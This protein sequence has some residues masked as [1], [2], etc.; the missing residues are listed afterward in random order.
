[1]IAQNGSKITGVTTDWLA[2]VTAIAEAQRWSGKDLFPHSGMPSFAI[3]N[4]KP[5]TTKYA[6]GLTPAAAESMAQRSMT[7]PA[8]RAAPRAVRA[9]AGRRVRP[10]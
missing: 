2:P 8:G 9:T 10:R 1:M 5:V 6:K 7:P 4:L 3:K